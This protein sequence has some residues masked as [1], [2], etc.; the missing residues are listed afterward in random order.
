MFCPPAS[1]AAIRSNAA[2]LPSLGFV[3]SSRRRAMGTASVASSSQRSPG[4]FHS[5]LFA[6][7]EM[8]QGAAVSTR[9]G[10]TSALTWLATNMRP[11]VSG[12]GA[13][14]AVSMSR[15]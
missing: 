9:M 4:I 1:H 2:S 14:P 10:S 5:V 7:G 3:G 8:G 6:I 15:K 13:F 12:S 11:P